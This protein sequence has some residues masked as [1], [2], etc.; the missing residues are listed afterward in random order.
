MSLEVHFDQL[1]KAIDTFA[2]SVE[3]VGD[4]KNVSLVHASGDGDFLADAHQLALSDL[5]SLCEI[6]VDEFSGAHRVAQTIFA[7]F[8][9]ADQAGA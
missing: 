7:G 6:A 9:A 1:H 2:A 4:S 3:A 5:G 8:E